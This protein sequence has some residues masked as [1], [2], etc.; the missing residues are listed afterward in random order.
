[1]SDCKKACNAAGLAQRMA[2]LALAVSL[3]SL[4][5]ISGGLTEI[6]TAPHFNL[7]PV[8]C[9]VGLFIVS[10]VIGLRYAGAQLRNRAERQPALALPIFA[11]L[12]TPPLLSL[13]ELVGRPIAYLIAV[14]VIG[15]VL[16]ALAAIVIRSRPFTALS[17]WI[18]AALH[19]AL[20]AWLLTAFGA[21]QFSL[22]WYVAHSLGLVAS[23]EV[24]FGVLSDLLF[25]ARH[26]AQANEE[27]ATLLR[28]DVLTG[29]ANRRAFDAALE[30]EWRRGYREQT[31]LSLLMVDIDNFKG[32]NDRYG[33]LAGDVCLRLVA[34]ALA[35]QAY[36]P[37]DLSARIGGEEFA[38]LLPVTEE[39]G[40]LQVAERLRAAV[41]NLMLPH[42]SSP[43]GFVTVS[44]GAAT[45]RPNTAFVRPEA[46]MGEAD[47]ALYRAKAQGRN[48]VC[49]AA[50]PLGLYLPRLLSASARAGVD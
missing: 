41:A 29:L 4:T 47:C 13:A 18:T 19:A 24:L 15:F 12:A 38:I 37:A 48:Q 45:L 14:A 5:L 20:L 6:R 8:C 1:M 26:A 7:V 31:A 17:L 46:L 11:A 33:H 2:A 21:P 10:L 27:M 30:T 49:L 39:A 44:I 22:S 42:Q 35:R 23:L 50:A 36:R 34:G 28:T 3:S 9:A 32:F 43:S 16:S 25:Q 40:A